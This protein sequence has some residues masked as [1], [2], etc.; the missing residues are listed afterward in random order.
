MN[1]TL[2]ALIRIVDVN[3]AYMHPYLEE[4]KAM[5]KL[6]VET[7]TANQAD[8]EMARVAE[9]SIEVWCTLLEKELEILKENPNAMT[10]IRSQDWKSLATIFFNGLTQIQFDLQDTSI[11]DET[12]MNIFFKINEVIGFLAQIVREP[13]LEMT[14]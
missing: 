11:D 13:M 2:E 1:S 12:D 7:A 3:Y 6:M 5:T 14:F 9:Y 8:T 10:L 4:T